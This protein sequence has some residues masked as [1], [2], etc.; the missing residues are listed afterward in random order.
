VSL[1]F[2]FKASNPCLIEIFLIVRPLPFSFGTIFLVVP[3]D[4]LLIVLFQVIILFFFSSTTV[5]F[6]S[7]LFCVYSGF[8]STTAELACA[9]LEIYS[10]F[11]LTVG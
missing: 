3:S 7:V 4:L 6:S 8:F 5:D 1:F 9:G 2:F 11:F 10:I